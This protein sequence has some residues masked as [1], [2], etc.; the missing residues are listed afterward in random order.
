MRKTNKINKLRKNTSNKNRNTMN[1]TN[2]INK[3]RKNTS[4][5]NTRNKNTRN[6][7]TRKNKHGGFWNYFMGKPQ[8]KQITN[9]SYNK[10]SN[11][12][13]KDISQLNTS[14]E[15]HNIYQECCPKRFGFKNSS[16]YCR[17]VEKGWLKAL[18]DENNAKGYYG[19]ETDP[20]QI[21]LD[22]NF[23][24]PEEKQDCSAINLD[25]I[26]NKSTLIS[27]YSKCCPTKFGFKKTNNIIVCKYL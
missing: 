20:E 2:K 15:L 12:E 8:N 26:T 27:L 17:Q 11:C 23:P 9:Q 19:E 6:K 18:R 21:E 25:N 22:M 4:N 24:V 1:K 3:L 16:T 10:L 5:K 7:N 13:Y 14:D